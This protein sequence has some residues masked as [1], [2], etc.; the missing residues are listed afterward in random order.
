MH[1][2]KVSGNYK[3]YK[4]VDEKLLNFYDTLVHIT[5]KI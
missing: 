1:E 3:A 5:D 2:N 4:L